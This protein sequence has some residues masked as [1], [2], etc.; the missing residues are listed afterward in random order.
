M[1]NTNAMLVAFSSHKSLTFGSQASAAL[2]KFGGNYIVCSWTWED[3]LKAYDVGVFPH[4]AT[5]EAMAQHYHYAGGSIRNMYMA[6][7]R[8]IEF[9]NGSVKKISDCKALLGGLTGMASLGFVNCLIQVFPECVSKGSILLS[10]YV[11]NVMR[12]KV[13]REFVNMAK[14]ICYSNKGWLGWVFEM[15]FGLRIKECCLASTQFILKGTP[16]FFQ[17]SDTKTL[18]VASYTDYDGNTVEAQ[19]LT[20]LSCMF[21]CTKIDQD[22]FD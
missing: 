16:S 18:T 20:E 17:W 1:P 4:F 9:I 21:I 5:K 22:C 10:V 12:Q 2:T 6:R 3:Y 19:H 15:D 7:E 13:G 8:L 11:C 14:S